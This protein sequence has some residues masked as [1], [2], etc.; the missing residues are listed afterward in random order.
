MDKVIHSI[1]SIISDGFK[2]NFSVEGFMNI[3]QAKQLFEFLSAHPEI[4]Y[5]AETGFNVGMSSSTMLSVGSHIKIY[6]F[7]LAEHNYVIKQKNLIDDLFPNQHVLIIGDSTKTIPQMIELVKE[8]VFDFLLIDGGHI[9]P[10][11]EK[12][13]RNLLKLLKPG[14]Y[15][16]VDDYNEMYGSKGVIQ[17]VNDVVNEKLVEKL[18]IYEAED[19]TWIYLRKL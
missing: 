4:K 5:I 6:S 10:V 7:D 13:I 3:A 15:I 11:P 16:Y 12:D 2:N 18:S 14:G 8:P 1:H 9:A 17:A 19:R